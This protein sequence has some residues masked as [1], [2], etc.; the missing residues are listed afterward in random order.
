MGSFGSLYEGKLSMAFFP[1]MHK[2]AKK[3][4]KMF[5]TNISREL[6]SNPLCFSWSHLITGVELIMDLC[7][8]VRCPKEN[9]DHLKNGVR[10]WTR[11]CS[12]KFLDYDV[13]NM[14]Q[15]LDV[16]IAATVGNF[17]SK[18]LLRF[19][20]MV[21]RIR[22]CTKYGNAIILMQFICWSTTQSVFIKMSRQL[23]PLD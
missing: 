22:S 18:E 19:V 1:T 9:A 21:T 14:I 16:L 12:H 6:W 17:L 7:H 11:S 3:M 23:P 10:P 20:L 15:S 13:H 5:P 2:L 4:E 8:V